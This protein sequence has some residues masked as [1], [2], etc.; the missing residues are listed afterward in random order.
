MDKL[1]FGLTICKKAFKKDLHRKRVTAAYVE[2]GIIII[3]NNS[4]KTHPLAS[5][6]GH[7]NNHTHAELDVLKYVKDGSN[8]KLYVYREKCD[9]SLG[10]ARPCQYCMKLLIAKN[11]RTVIYT[12]ETGY[13]KERIFS[14]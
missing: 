8:G 6:F 12:T 7:R 13:A 5:T 9:G 2:N 3:G 1:P 4:R 10:L 11:I 14:S